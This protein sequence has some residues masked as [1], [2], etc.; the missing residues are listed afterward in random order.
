M[1]ELLENNPKDRDIDNWLAFLLLCW[2]C[3]INLTLTSFAIQLLQHF[4]LDVI[5]GSQVVQQ[6]LISN[7]KYLVIII[8]KGWVAALAS[9]FPSRIIPRYYLHLLHFLSFSAPL[10]FFS[11]F[12]SWINLYSYQSF[13]TPLVFISAFASRICLSISAAASGVSLKLINPK[14]TEPIA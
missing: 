10:F 8:D 5:N 14:T 1:I 2:S 4:S 3:D 13:R 11:N 7:A 9:G 6:H 12:A